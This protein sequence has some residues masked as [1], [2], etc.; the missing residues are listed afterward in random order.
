MAELDESNRDPLTRAAVRQLLGFAAL[1]V[2][3]FALLLAVLGFA[4][5]RTGAGAAA[6]PAVDLATRS[7]TT[8]IRD[9]PPNLDSTR[10]IDAYSNM[11]L[12]HVM[13]GLMRPGEHG[14]IQ[15]GVAERWDIRS[16]GATFWLRE[17]AVWSD[18]KPVT[19]HDFVFA[20]RT[21]LDPKTASQ[22]AFI[23]YP[24]KNGE[25]INRGDLP[26]ENLGVT[27]I[28]DRVLEVEFQNPL[29]YFDKMAAWMTY[30]PIR[31]DFYRSRNGRYAAD[32][33]DLLYNGPFMLTR[34]VH[35]ANLRLEK[36]P[37]YWN[38][39]RVKLN[40]IDIAYITRDAVARLNLYQDG[41]VSDVDY[42]PGEALDQVLQQRWPLYRY[43]DGSI[44]F[45]VLNF[46]SGH[47]TNNHHFRRALQL[48]NDPVELV[49][50]VLK[51]PSYTPAESL[52]PSFIRGENALFRQEHPPP[53]VKTDI[54]AARAELEI[55]KRELGIK[56]FPPLVFLSDD[57]PAA[58]SQSEYEQEYY[59]RTLGL[60]IKI[61]RQN[62]R[63]RLD[64]Q[65][66]GEFD[67]TLFGWSAD[68]DDPLSF[69]DLLA[70]WNLNNNGRYS[71][72]ELDA[73]VRIAQQSLDPHVRFG[74]FAEIQRILIDDAA[75]VMSFERGV[76]FVQDRRLK[77]V[78]HRAV[79]PYVDYS[80]AY[81]VDDR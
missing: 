13:E 73:Q 52:F 10:A 58:V 68:Y 80:Y 64:K 69:A 79:G 5:S 42:L 25:A 7:I 59:R 67:I 33:Q 57:T 44:W 19:A 14:D 1:S 70:S 78:V 39:D 53:P 62:F 18:G 63:Q 66:N 72:P 12:G 26:P 40:A 37:T 56:E 65:K 2:A 36:N 32:A 3:G 11:I 8:T 21:A 34:W 71:S 75:L 60:E 31:E 38:H 4:S 49:Y 9:E 55:A 23:L 77:N 81:L 47:V 20:W 22:Y 74:A 27:A 76:L 48:A 24:V 17:A 6:L 50:K 15:P 30:L 43:N 45:L 35:G 51:T 46:R 28:S 41:R 16:T 29:A 54:A 61:D